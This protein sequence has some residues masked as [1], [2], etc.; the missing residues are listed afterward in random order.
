[1]K[2]IA[3]VLK[4]SPEFGGG[5]QYAVLVAE[6]LY[7]NYELVVICNNDFWYRWCRKRRIKYF[8]WNVNNNNKIKNLKKW[9]KYSWIIK[10][11][12]W[13]FSDIGKF[14]RKEKINYIIC[15]Q[16]G[17]LIPPLPCKI[18]YPIHDLMHRYEKEFP[19]VKG[20]YNF[21]EL[22]YK[23]VV[24]NSTVILTDS[25]LGKRQLIESYNIDFKKNKLK[26]YVLPFCASLGIYG[27]EEYI[28]VPE[29]Y[30]FY[31][32]Q[33]WK[34]KNHINLIKAI[35]ILKE[36]IPDIKLILVGSEQNVLEEVIDYI[37]EH[38]L[39]EQVFIYG[40]VSNGIVKYLYQHAVMLVMPTFFGPTNIPPLEAMALGC[41]VA[42]SNKYAMK[43]QVGKAG[44]LFSPDSPKEIA[45]C[46]ESVWNDDELRKRMV[47]E[48]YKRTEKWN[49]NS[50]E[51]RFLKII[52]VC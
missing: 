32:A 3:V 24:K 45:A 31:P 47:D 40:Y 16:Q 25:Q 15:A 30:I 2:K 12:Y 14:L 33:F 42:V 39:S 27:E 35:E 46:V 7:K 18:V 22:L 50:F 44:L 21:R 9:Y 26:I 4:T 17:T 13:Y 6:C 10:Y 5:H 41:P 8:K 38:D 43:E 28:D 36:K 52:S 49:K 20:E 11:Y 48:G 1:M 23:N 29:K 51:E 34:H 37:E 19:E